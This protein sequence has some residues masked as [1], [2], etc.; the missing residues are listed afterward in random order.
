MT[1]EMLRRPTFVALEPEHHRILSEL[2]ASEGTTIS[3]LVRRAVIQVFNLP[4]GRELAAL[5]T[6][7]P[8][9]GQSAEIDSDE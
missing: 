6:A 1:H 7:S 2:A 8:F 9:A 5:R 4:T 3:A